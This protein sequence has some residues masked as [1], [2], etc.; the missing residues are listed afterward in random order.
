MEARTRL[1]NRRHHGKERRQV[2]G[3]EPQSRSCEKR[4]GW[5]FQILRRGTAKGVSWE[6]SV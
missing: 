4:Q 5:L 6:W 1:G 2:C 3:E